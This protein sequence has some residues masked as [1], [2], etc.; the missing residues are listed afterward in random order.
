MPIQTAVPIR[1]F[2]QESFHQVDRRVTGLA[3]D[4]QNEF[5]RYLDESL[6]QAELTRR[7]RLLG[8][9]VEPELQIDVGFGDFCKSYYADH[10]INQGVII[11]DKAVS[12]LE[13]VHKGQALNYLFLC[14]LHHG[15]LLNFGAESVQHEFVS[16]RLTHIDR[17][18]YEVVAPHWK[19]LTR[20]CQELRDLLLQLLD[21]WGAYLDPLLYEEALIHFLGGQERIEHE[22]RVT[23]G[24]TV[25]GSQKRLLLTDN[26][27]FA[28]T[29]STHR[30]ETV[31]EHQRRFL[32]QT[33]LR[34]LQWINLNH[35]S[36]ELRTIER[37]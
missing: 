25:I 13:S 19:P 8:L 36:I 10:L 1:V 16:T 32:R 27:A 3:F 14:G 5:G 20:R 12:A 11:E 33:P 26:I 31:L 23:S 37:Q 28:V 30:L 24:G 29:A 4:I 17:R 2:D 15:T 6:Y 35:K 18:R 34:A 9:E 7:C 22:I 21:E